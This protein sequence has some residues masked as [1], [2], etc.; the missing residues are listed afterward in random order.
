MRG[1]LAFP[2]RNLTYGSVFMIETPL[3]ATSPSH[4]QWSQL[5]LMDC[6]YATFWLP[7]STTHDNNDALAGTKGREALGPLPAAR[8]AGSVP[9][10]LDEKQLV[11]RLHV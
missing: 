1:A 11:G 4:S 8:K 6:L 7:G 10:T 2:I 3:A 9:K 5:G